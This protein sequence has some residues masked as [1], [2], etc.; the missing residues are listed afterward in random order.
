MHAR[1]Q[2]ALLGKKTI[3]IYVRKDSPKERTISLNP[4]PEG[5]DP[6]TLL[7]AGFALDGNSATFP[8]DQYTFAYDADEENGDITAIRSLAGEVEDAERGNLYLEPWKKTWTLTKA[9]HSVETL[10]V[11]WL[12]KLG[13]EV[14]F[15]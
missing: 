6:L 2:A 3:T 7:N 8:V 15:G 4:I 12:H 5:V 13:Y 9:V 1:A 10:L 14:K 11:N